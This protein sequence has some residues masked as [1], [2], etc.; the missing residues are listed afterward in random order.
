MD[1]SENESQGPKQKF[2]LGGRTLRKTGLEPI[3]ERAKFLNPS[4]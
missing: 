4:S 1:P 2:S 3:V